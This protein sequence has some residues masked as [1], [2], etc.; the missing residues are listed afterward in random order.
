MKSPV[1]QT[2]LTVFSTLLLVLCNIPASYPGASM[3]TADVSVEPVSLDSNA[4]TSLQQE[5]TRQEKTHG[6]VSFQDPNLHPDHYRYYFNRHP[7][8]AEAC[9]LDESCPYKVKEK[10]NTLKQRNFQFQ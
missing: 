6:S 1:L 3:E 9:R 4:L 2:L 7:E 10:W 5:G 8:D